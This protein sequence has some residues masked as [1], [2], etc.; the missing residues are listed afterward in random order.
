MVRIFWYAAFLGSLLAI[1]LLGTTSWLLYSPTGTRWLLNH[2]PAW[3]DTELNIG[4]IEGTLGGKLQLDNIELRHQDLQLQ[5]DHFSMQNRRNSLLP[6][7]LEIG[8]LRVEQLQIKSAPDQSKKP[9]GKFTWPKTP[10]LLK[11]LYLNLSDIEIHDFSW[12]QQGQQPIQ[13]ELFRGNL[14][15][16]NS[17]LMSSQFVIKTTTLQSSGSFNCGL[18]QPLLQLET[19]I[20]ARDSA[21][22][23]RQLR[24]KTD[25]KPG[26]AEQILH[27]S[28]TL[29]ITGSKGELLAAQTELGLT[30]EQLQ[31]QQLQISR[32]KRSGKITASGSVQ[33]SGSTPELISKLKFSKLDLQAET[34]QP[35]QLSGEVQ[36]KGNLKAY[37][38]QFD[39]KNHG[40][41][42][43]NIN[44]AGNFRGD[45]EQ[46]S[47]YK[48]HGEWLQGI[49]S[50]QAQISWKDGWL[51]KTQLVGQ[52]I[53]PQSLHPQLAGR[54][55]LD[56]QAEF[57]AASQESPHGL[58][59]LTLH[60]SILH[61]QPLS[62]TAQ[63]Q[64]Q[65]N[66]LQ[67]KQLQL[68]GAGMQLQASGNPAEKLIVNW[69][70]EQLEQLLTDATGQCSGNG[71]LRWHEQKLA[72]N[73]RTNAEAL[74]FQGWRLGKLTLQ[75]ETEDAA[76]QWQLQLAGQLLHNQ[77]LGL[78]VE[79]IKI[80]I[81][82]SLDDQQL[83][84]SLTQQPSSISANL[85]GGWDGQQWRGQLS[86]FQ[87][88]DSRIGRWHLLQ[89]VPVILSTNLLSIDLL[90]LSN[91]NGSELQL[92]ADY[93]LEQQQGNA[94]VRWQKLDLSLLRPVLSDW[95][96]SG[97][98]SG[99][100][101]LEQGQSNRL[102]GEIT[103]SGELQRQELQLK[104]SNSKIRIDWNEQGLQ[105]T[106]QII[107]ANG[108]NL[109]GTL[110][111]SQAA[112]FSLPQEGDLQLTG[113]DFPLKMFTPWLP[114]ELNISGALDWNTTGHWQAEQPLKLQGVATTK[115]GHF[116]WQDDDGILTADI[117][118]AELSWQWQNRLQGKL[119]VQLREQGSIEAA[120]DLPLSA[121]L[122]LA[123]DQTAAMNAD[124][125]TRLRE[126]GLLSIFFPNRVQESHGQLNLDLQ[127][128]GN[129]LQPHL[130]GNFHLYDAGIFLPSV[131][132]QLKE[133]E[134]QG[135]FAENRVEIAKLQLGSGK[136]KLN[137]SGQLELQSWRPADYS[138]QLKG[139]NFQ[140]I[141]LPEL[142]VNSNP[143][144]KIDG[145]GKNIKVRGQIE[146]PEVLISG[147]QKTTRATNS[148]DLLV[149]DREAP[150]THQS[151]LKHD[152]D[153]KLILGKRVLLNTA[154]ID[155]RLEGNLRLQSDARQE[156]AGNGEIR[157]AKG[158]YSSY[159]VSL[160]I[161]RGNLLFTGG[162]LDQPTLDIL[163]LRK[164]GEVQV[165][166]KVTGTP[167]APIVK[168]YSEPI[169]AETDILSY[170][171]IGRPIG[172]ESGQT[173]LLMLAAGALLSQGE[174]VVLQEKLKS[175]FGLDVLDVSSTDGN[176]NSSIITT[177]KYLSPDLY[178]SFGYSL[179]NNTNEVKV[180]YSITPTWEV[181]SSLGT[182]SG[183]DMYYRI[184]IE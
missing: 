179:F 116:S 79:Q 58:L 171:V 1:L 85:S 106:L 62:G 95:L 49:L 16:Q 57:G 110:T 7:T 168:L 72:V 158:K 129:W 103:A 17:K 33:F 138:L 88:A 108:G 87:G 84:L 163:A 141:N 178:L 48:L 173:D 112:D 64:L 160:E 13:I 155:A 29:D 24:L 32:P 65:D 152:I 140:L 143:E 67:I 34:G 165:G 150:P 146:F 12:Q 135:N 38:G 94:N 111:S 82:G 144:L 119:E 131:G 161:S 162:P 61:D 147:E 117:D 3:T 81:F 44:L 41:G 97:M 167:K 19:V 4:H 2:L 10:W 177:G 55:N 63:F 133:I 18:K 51:L 71:W 56:L 100:L 176:V 47:L 99:S 52:K 180:R 184:E 102:H 114:P 98:S 175:R 122:P 50:G 20:D 126:R 139:E 101:D 86:S 96:I 149:V 76:G 159:G 5:I 127:L 35:L 154:G 25:L 40:T 130:H 22:A 21:A 46:L 174:S 145:T 134:L 137:G 172:A 77:Q 93:H 91:H 11:Q 6:L 120:F 90:S 74:S 9:A 109:L 107:L 157:I 132:V 36:I 170:I 69:Q 136:G 75:A 169:M 37:S 182:E 121:R 28:A 104:L 59:Q 80:D 14:S 156:L 53:D 70:I 105:S 30:Q 128:T 115:T 148:P 60:D 31:F 92:Q 15:W 68:H 42:V 27:G 125:H 151:K 142:Q 39:L 164:A 45:L 73:L 183:I 123:F 78:E 23:W 8:L 89:P 43:S 54:L 166:V 83:T 113:S 26:S 181:E 118:A 66:S 153:L 124:L